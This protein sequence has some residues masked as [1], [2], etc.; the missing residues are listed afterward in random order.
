MESPG[1]VTY[2]LPVPLS[3]DRAGNGIRTRDINLGKVA[4]YQLSYSRKAGEIYA[5]RPEKSSPLP[6][7]LY[8]VTSR[9]SYF[10]SP[11]GTFTSIFSP[12]FFPSKA[13]PIGD[14][15]EILLLS[16]SDSS[17]ETSRYSCS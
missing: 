1:A 14:V 16:K 4:L 9:I 12:C 11:T 13:L 8:L 17:G 5:L 6:L 15:T 10:R 3:R 2:R 7:L